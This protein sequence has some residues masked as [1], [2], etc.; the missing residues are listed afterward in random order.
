M[1][2]MVIVAGL[3]AEIFPTP[4]QSQIT[5]AEADPPF[6]LALESVVIIG[7]SDGPGIIGK[8][9][10]VQ[11]RK[12]GE[13]VVT[14][15]YNF[16]EIKFFSFEGFWVRTI[17]RRGQGPGEFETAWFLH[18]TPDDG[19]AVVDIGL[20]RVTDL[21]PSLEVKASRPITIRPNRMVF[22]K[23][24]FTLVAGLH[25]GRRSVGLPLH[26]LDSDGT[27]VRSFGADPPIK[28]ASDPFAVWRTLSVGGGPEVWAA[29]LTR[30]MVEK[31]T[32][33]GVRLKAFEREVTWFQPHNEY[34][35]RSGRDHP[36]GPGVHALFEDDEGRLWT[37]IHVPDEHWEDAYERGFDPYGREAERVKD[38]NLFFDTVIEVIDTDLG[39][40]LG[41]VRM[42]AAVLSFTEEGRIVTYRF[43]EGLVPTIEVF[44]VQVTDQ[45]GGAS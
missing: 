42:D 43:E 16:S 41:S 23:D 21:F 1:R 13:W 4:A 39:T 34:G 2:W 11:Q 36:P 24:N 26:V 12:N 32:T 10:D 20:L 38:Q 19:L 14:D 7:D 30:Y 45:H 40:V 9:A 35:L 37:A 17:G 44:E 25:F 29:P 27:I 31:W 3:V 22:L 5:L 18:V 8:P 6:H 15:H 28:E 33:D